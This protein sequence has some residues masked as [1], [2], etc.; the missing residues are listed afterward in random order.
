MRINLKGDYQATNMPAGLSPPFSTTSNF[1][2]G[3]TFPG[4][5]S[6]GYG[7]DV[8]NRFTVGFDFK[9]SQNS[10]T[11]DLPLLIG[12]NQ[13]LLGTSGAVLNWKN[14]I[15]L[16]T[17][18]TYQLDENWVLRGGYLFSENSQPQASYTP[19]APANDRHVFS[20]GVGWRGKT[21]GVDL[22]YAYVYNPTRVI[23]GATSNPP[24]QFDGSYT[25]QWQ[26]LSLSITQRF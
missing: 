18:M 23:S 16:G 21:R 24:G 4:S 20:F 2:S 19:L 1:S 5:I 8:T 17:G 14:S 22:T 25:H 7:F 11:Y 6:V 26:V 10:S 3:M 12:N 15:D 13:P 9:W